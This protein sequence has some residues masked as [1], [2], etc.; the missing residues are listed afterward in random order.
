VCDSADTGRIK[1]EWQFRA[2][3]ENVEPEGVLL[4]LPEYNCVVVSRVLVSQLE[5]LG[6]STLYV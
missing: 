3:N 2:K 1:V 5:R 6:N 4:D